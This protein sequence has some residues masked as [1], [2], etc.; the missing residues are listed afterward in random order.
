[1]SIF[2][3][4]RLAFF[5]HIIYT[6]IIQFTKEGAEMS[7]KPVSPANDMTVGPE[8]KKIL[9]FALP[10]MAGQFLQQL[11]NTVDGIV[12]GN[13][14]S[15]AALG[16]VGACT[17]L[18]F[19][20]LSISNGFGMGCGVMIS[21]L[22]G[23]KRMDDVKRAVSTGLILLTAMGLAAMLL[24]RFGAQWLVTSVLNIS[25]SHLI[26]LSVTY[27]SIVSLGM[28]FQF[29]YN[30][31]ASIL[32]AVGD[33]KATLYFLCVSAVMNLILDVVFVAY[34]DWGVAGAAIATVIS[35]IACVIVCFIYMFSKYPMF[36]FH[37][38]EF[39]FSPDLGKL[40]L[41]LGAPMTLQQAIVSC[42]NV[43]MQRLVNYFGEVT[44]A[45]FTC[46]MRIENYAMI[47]AM[48]FNSAMSMFTGQN[49]GA[50]KPDRIE[51]GWRS[52]V[53]M[54]MCVT[55]V[56]ATVLFVGAYPLSALFGVDGE[57]QLQAVDYIRFVS[58]M[59]LI[60]SVYLTTN[61]VVQGSGDALYASIC[62]FSTLGVRV[63]LAY[64]L[65]FLF[66]FDYHVLWRC[67][68]IGWMFAM[69]LAL[70]YFLKGKWKNKSVI[71]GLAK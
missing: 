18:S 48:G 7:A 53:K 42:G 19:L 30:C 6:D 36:R 28:V 16:A 37:R 3:E 71:G 10:I 25:E 23:A 20:F 49:I 31:V 39:R 69:I 8:W 41:K 11:Y 22:F 4:P 67:I 26:E 70:H 38:G 14:V 52:A 62:S 27:F 47:P 68:P 66:N 1:M 64:A 56:I 57:A 40:C 13:F 9:F 51:R 2:R 24:G 15:E 45:A 55:F 43:I 34:F 61:G 60:F 33:S 35:Q 46:G 63:A 32:R 54:A 29:L 59:M 44:M 50:N 17:T 58:Y 12:V 21:Q 65:V 5:V